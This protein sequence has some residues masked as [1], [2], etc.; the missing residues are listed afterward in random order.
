MPTIDIQKFLQDFWYKHSTF[1]F[2]RGGGGGR[3]Q[4]RHVKDCRVGVSV[5]CER[6]LLLTLTG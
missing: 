5:N 4:L 2:Y 1:F 6:F 3:F